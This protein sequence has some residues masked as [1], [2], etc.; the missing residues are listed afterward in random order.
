MWPLINC[1]QVAG[2]GE[3]RTKVTVSRN[4]KHGHLP[5]VES[6]PRVIRDK[7]THQLLGYPKSEINSLDIITIN[8]N[9]SLIFGR[10]LHHYEEHTYLS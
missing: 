2:V 1:T 8:H 9:P 3:S 5:R 7:R 6:N 10:R 4:N